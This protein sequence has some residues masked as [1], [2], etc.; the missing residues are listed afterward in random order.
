MRLRDSVLPAFVLEEIYPCHGFTLL[1]VTRL[2]GSMSIFS[3]LK[4]SKKAAKMHKKIASEQIS[5]E[6]VPKPPYKHIPTHAY[7]DALSGCPSSWMHEDRIKIM[8]QRAERRSMKSTDPS[9]S[10]QRENLP[11]AQSLY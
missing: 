7:L 3:R 1:E 8:E 5:A 11:H 6:N 2:A 9:L 10:S 4:R